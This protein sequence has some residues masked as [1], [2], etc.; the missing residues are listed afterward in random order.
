MVMAKLN[1]QPVKSSL[2]TFFLLTPST[3]SGPQ[4]LQRKQFVNCSALKGLLC[5][6][7]SFAYQMRQGQDK[8]LT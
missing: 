2:F 6:G 7:F 3:L 4:S 5:L 1:V 8:G